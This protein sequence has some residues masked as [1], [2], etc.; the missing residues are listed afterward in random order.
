MGKLLAERLGFG[1]VD[2]DQEIIARENKSVSEM[3]AA[4]GWE[5]FRDRESE[6]LAQCS[7]SRVVIA[8][9]GGVILRA[10]NRAWLKEHGWNCWLMITPEESCRRIQGSADR[11]PLT[12][13][14][15]LLTEMR[16]VLSVREPLYRE[17][18][19]VSISTGGK[20]PE[21][22]SDEILS[23]YQARPHL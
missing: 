19:N 20:S 2:M 1:F 23:H 6:A 16:D 4:Y 3:V 8:T 15:D 22:I 7:L 17:V 9:G 21:Q 12:G 5:Y 11:P 14:K 18:A 10:Q 13:A